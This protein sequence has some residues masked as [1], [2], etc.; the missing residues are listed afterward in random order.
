MLR[1]LGQSRGDLAGVPR[2]ARGVPNGDADRFV[3]AD[4]EVGFAI[5]DE[6][7]AAAAVGKR[8]GQARHPEKRRARFS[9]DVHVKQLHRSGDQQ[10]WLRR[11]H[12]RISPKIGGGGPRGG[13]CGRAAGYG[14]RQSKNPYSDLL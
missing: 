7:R 8:T 10:A 4:E 12:V 6:R 11:R 9:V 1:A 3:L 14:K 5:P 13:R 2:N